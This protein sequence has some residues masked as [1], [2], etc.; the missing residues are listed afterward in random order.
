MIGRVAGGERQALVTAVGIWLAAV[1]AFALGTSDPWW[2]SISALI[3]ANPDRSALVQKAVLRLIGTILGCIIGFYAALAL[4]GQAV[5]QALFLFGINTACVLMRFRSRFSYAWL[6]GGLTIDM[7]MI[8][9]I[10]APDTL[11][12]F[13]VFRGTEISVGVLAALAAALVLGRDVH[14]PPASPAPAAPTRMEEWHAALIG[15]TM[16]PVILVAWS[17][18]ALPSLLQIVISAIAV[19]DRDVT[20]MRTKGLHRILGCLLGGSL[21]LFFTSLGIDSFIAW[22][23]V[24]IA[25]LYALVHVHHGPARYAYVGTQGAL[26]FIITM[27]TGPGPPSSIEPIVDRLAGMLSG[28]VL[29]LLVVT[30]LRP[31]LARLLPAPAPA[32]PG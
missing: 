14:G 26:G 4:E 8:G 5:A 7:A 11:Y 3:I 31:V 1:F 18:L 13:V 30:M 25:G 29:L 9:S 10:D 22:S 19:I 20:L 24:F 27:V 15:G 23:L 12:S 17:L 21:G 28:V 6:L 2:A 32:A 16:L